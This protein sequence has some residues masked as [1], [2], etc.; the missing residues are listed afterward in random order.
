MN[1]WKFV[2]VGVLNFG[3]RWVVCV[4]VF[5]R[6]FLML[7]LLS[8]CG[9]SVRFCWNIWKVVLVGVLNLIWFIRVFC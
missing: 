1:C 5:F 9:L 2:V 4:I 3:V 6:V 7:V 8:V